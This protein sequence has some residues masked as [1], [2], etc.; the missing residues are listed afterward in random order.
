MRP[1]F[2]EA[3]LNGV[4]REE[5]RAPPSRNDQKDGDVCRSPDLDGEVLRNALTDLRRD[6]G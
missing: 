5:Q 6:L 4:R 2:D 3:A 1:R